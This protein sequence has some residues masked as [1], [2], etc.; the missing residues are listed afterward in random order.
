MKVL[1]MLIPLTIEGLKITLGVFIL[2]LAV[3]LPLSILV[4]LMR[5]SKISFYLSLLAYIYTL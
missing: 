5:R 2:T 3:S 1:K 4:A